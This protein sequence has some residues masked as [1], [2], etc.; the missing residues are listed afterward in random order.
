LFNFN[1][2]SYAKSFDSIIDLYSDCKLS[3]C[4]DATQW[5]DFRQG[6]RGQVKMKWPTALLWQSNITFFLYG[7]KYFFL[8][9]PVALFSQLGGKLKKNQIF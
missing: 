4:G 6:T 2:W 5:S 8:Q 7:K 9:I 3:L 1:V